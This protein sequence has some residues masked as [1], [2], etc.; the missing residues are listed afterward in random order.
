MSTMMQNNQTREPGVELRLHASVSLCN[1]RLLIRFNHRR[2][3]PASPEY[4]F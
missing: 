1:P 4:L 3:Q 2:P